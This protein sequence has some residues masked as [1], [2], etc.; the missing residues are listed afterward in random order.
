[1]M[2][3]DD[4]FRILIVDDNKELREIL[5]EYLKGEG[6]DAEGAANGREALER[7]HQEPFDLIITDLNMPEVPGMELIKTIRK[8]NQDTEF[9]IIT[10]YASMDSAVEAVRIGAF[11]YIVKPFRMEELQVV[12]KNAR[13]KITL[14]KLNAKLV[15]T[16]QSFYDEM[17]R[18][19]GKKPEERE[20][21]DEP[22]NGKRASDTEQIVA[23]IRNLKKLRKGRLL[24][25]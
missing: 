19:R 3:N 9:V 7:Q 1:M 8:E 4:P 15:Q 22:A 23:E 20:G 10:G 18:Y 16:L 21:M 17:E 24:I 2:K 11:D 13:D 14:K 6:H 12:V 25:E 5:Q